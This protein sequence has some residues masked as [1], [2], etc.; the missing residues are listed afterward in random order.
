M[1]GDWS[2]PWLIVRRVLGTPG[3]V[4]SYQ[5]REPRW[6][7]VPVGVE[8]VMT[9]ELVAQFVWLTEVKAEWWLI[10]CPLVFALIEWDLRTY[11]WEW[12]S[13]SGS[14]LGVRDT[15]FWIDT[16]IVSAPKLRWTR[17]CAKRVTISP[18]RWKYH[19]WRIKS[20]RLSV[21]WKSRRAIVPITSNPPSS[22]KNIEGKSRWH[23]S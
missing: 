8:P 16:N 11:R 4:A 12:A 15:G 1:V 21:Y 10:S 19:G 13:G 6:V 18:L 5:V 20:L 9:T 2:A 23:L 17:L 14:F 22:A 7:S 3:M